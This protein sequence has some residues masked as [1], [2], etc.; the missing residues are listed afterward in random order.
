MKYLTYK[1][2]IDP[3]TII[4]HTR[5]YSENPKPPFTLCS[6]H[7]KLE[8]PTLAVFAI[9][10]RRASIFPDFPDDTVPFSLYTFLTGRKVHPHSFKQDSVRA[11]SPILVQHPEVDVP[12]VGNVFTNDYLDTIGLPRILEFKRPFPTDLA[13]QIVTALSA[14]HRGHMSLE[15]IMQAAQLIGFD[16]E[17]ISSCITQMLFDRTILQKGASGYFVLNAP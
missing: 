14:E 2:L 8:F 3:L 4:L 7:Q 16:R 11:I 17:A 9:L 15:Q 6:M 12:D 5:N 10:F 13:Y 1:L